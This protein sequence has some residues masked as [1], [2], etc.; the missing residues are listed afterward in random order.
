MLKLLTFVCLAVACQTKNLDS[1][2]LLYGTYKVVY[3]SPEATQPIPCTE[4]VFSKPPADVN[5]NCNCE[6]PP[7]KEI[8][9]HEEV[10]SSQ[11]MQF[12]LLVDF[13]D[14]AED[15][16]ATVAN[17]CTCTPSNRSRTI[18]QKGEGDYLLQYVQGG[19]RTY[20]LAKEVPKPEELKAFINNLP[21]LKNTKGTVLCP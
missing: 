14:N 20:V 6:N 19:Q 18:I 13:V 7:K 9:I 16:E 4:V 5:I 8:I 3:T 1:G 21:N 11:N 10:K 12:N 15:L 2:D 17:K